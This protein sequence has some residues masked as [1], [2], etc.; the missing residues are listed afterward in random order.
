MP[1]IQEVR[2]QNLVEWHSVEP[3][4]GRGGPSREGQSRSLPFAES[5]CSA[6]QH[7]AGGGDAA[8]LDHPFVQ[9]VVVEINDL[10]HPV[11]A[12]VRAVGWAVAARTTE[13][14]T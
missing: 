7:G 3:W 6:G 8:Q 5:S 9:V 11:T 10:C 4:L 1:V 14:A 12:V 2:F 13:F